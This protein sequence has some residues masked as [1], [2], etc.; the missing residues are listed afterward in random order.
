VTDK[1][2]IVLDASPLINLIGSG[3]PAPLLRA[4]R[5]H[6]I[7][8]DITLREIVR[9]PRTGGDLLAVIDSLKAENL[10]AVT[11]LKSSELDLFVEL[12][13]SPADAALGD[14]EAA[15]LALALN[16]AHA[17]ILDDGKAKRLAKL[18]DPQLQIGSSLDL[19]RVARNQSGL[20]SQEFAAAVYEAL[21]FARMRVSSEDVRWVADIIGVDRLSACSSVRRHLREELAKADAQQQASMPHTSL[22]AAA[23][24]GKTR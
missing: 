7:I 9:S 8:A 6:V 2:T 5:R 12:V 14:G 16:R 17:M 3:Y 10:I 11:E 21:Q 20:S 18:R 13:S 15:A 23:V 24:P 22:K 4:L 19:F 1:P